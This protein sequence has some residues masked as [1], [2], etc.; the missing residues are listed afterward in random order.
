MMSEAQFPVRL[1]TTECDQLTQAVYFLELT[2]W[3]ELP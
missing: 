1:W 3:K 2:Q